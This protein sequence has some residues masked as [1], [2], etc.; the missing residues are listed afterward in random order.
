M[1]RV[2][3]VEDEMGNRLD[4]RR[5]LSLNKSWGDVG[6]RC[7]DLPAPTFST[8]DSC[9]SHHFLHVRLQSASQIDS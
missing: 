3:Y 5:I 8:L 4:Q 9:A 2:D 7:L 6:Q 1:L